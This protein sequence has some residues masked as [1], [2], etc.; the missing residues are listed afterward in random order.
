MDREFAFTEV[1][2]LF[3]GFDEAGAVG[4]REGEAVLND[5]QMLDAGCGM[6]DVRGRVFQPHNHTF[7][8]QPLVALLGNED[9]RFCQRQ[10]RGKRQVEGDEC[11][12]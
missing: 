7:Q 2:G 4:G 9:E 8:E 12:A 6:L 3:A 10:L 1:V 5:G 11:F